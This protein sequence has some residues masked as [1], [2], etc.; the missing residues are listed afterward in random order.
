MIVYQVANIHIGM[1]IG[2]VF[3][4]EVIVLMA[5]MLVLLRNYERTQRHF[6]ESWRDGYGLV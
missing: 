1:N 2:G 3:R 5:D 4:Q 6:E